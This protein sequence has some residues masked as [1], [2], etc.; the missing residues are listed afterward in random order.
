MIPGCSC[1][2]KKL[3]DNLENTYS[4]YLADNNNTPPQWAPG[5]D[6]RLANNEAS[7]SRPTGEAGRVQESHWYDYDVVFTAIVQDAT[8]PTDLG[9]RVV[10]T[11]SLY[12]ASTMKF[13]KGTTIRV[14]RA[15]GDSYGDA[16]ETKGS[17]NYLRGKQSITKRSHL[18]E[19]KQ[20]FDSSSKMVN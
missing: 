9:I 15:E 11:N 19:V 1:G 3:K 6:L 17:F 5:R 4:T 10:A 16:V 7:V 2:L 13:P 20:P 14:V 8:L 12:D 18:I